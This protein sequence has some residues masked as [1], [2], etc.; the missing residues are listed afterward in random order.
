MMMR[1]AT[2]ANLGAT[3][4]GSTREQTRSG[5]AWSLT[6]TGIDASL[7]AGSPIDR[8]L[9]SLGDQCRA[10]QPDATEIESGKVPAGDNRLQTSPS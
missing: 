3:G 2:L 6:Q 10:K 9:A 4:A 8:S 1:T 7:P 5:L